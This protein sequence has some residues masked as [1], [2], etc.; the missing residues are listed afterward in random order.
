MCNRALRFWES[1]QNGVAILLY[2]ERVRPDWEPASPVFYAALEGKLIGMLPDA[3]PHCESRPG[4]FSRTRVVCNDSKTGQKREGLQGCAATEHLTKKPQHGCKNIIFW[5]HVRNSKWFARR[6][7]R[8]R[9]ILKNLTYTNFVRNLTSKLGR[10]TL[11][12]P[13]WIRVNMA[14]NSL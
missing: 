5:R 14:T 1:A 3:A 13:G 12:S 4:D 2:L 6:F 9:S 10:S 7:C 11:T 8:N